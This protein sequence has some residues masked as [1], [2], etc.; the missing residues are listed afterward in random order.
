[1]IDTHCHLTSTALAPRWREIVD[2]AAADGVSAVIS[3]AVDLADARAASELAAADDRV[4]CTAGVHPLHCGED[5]DWQALAALAADERCVAWGELGLDRHWEDPPQQAQESLLTEHLACIEGAGDAKPVVVHC[6]GAVPRLLEVLGASSID[7]SRFIF[8]CFTEGPQDVRAVLDFGAWVG[9]TGV[10]TFSNAPEV[11]ESALL[12]P[13]DRMLVETDAPYLSPE[14]VR[15]MRP[16]EP[17]TVVHV[18]RHL[19]AI[20]DVAEGDLEAQLDANARRL[21][22]LP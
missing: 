7:A 8:H 22:R 6:R 12:V 1:M 17:R 21:F 9:F 3:V 10:V 2:S 19:A 4:F 16:N 13:L 15:S 5:C 14:P 11:V 18:A 20:R